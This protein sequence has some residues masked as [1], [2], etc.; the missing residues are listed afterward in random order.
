MFAEVIEYLE[1]NFPKQIDCK[2]R[3]STKQINRVQNIYI[4]M[5]K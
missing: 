3:V 1:E 5:S 2:R 4:E